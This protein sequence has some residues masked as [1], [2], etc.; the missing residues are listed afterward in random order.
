MERTCFGMSLEQLVCCSQPVAKYAY[1]SIAWPAAPSPSAS[2]L[3]PL[4][5]SSAAMYVP[6]ELARLLDVIYRSEV[7]QQIV[8]TKR[9][10]NECT[11]LYCTVLY[12][13]GGRCMKEPGLFNTPGEPSEVNTAA[14][15]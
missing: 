11:V 5:L 1:A 4:S 2:P 14:P 13:Q 7:P 6:K 9:C 12:T 15:E 10:M 8:C 3:L